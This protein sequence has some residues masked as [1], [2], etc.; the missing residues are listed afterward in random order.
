MR[1]LV[2]FASDLRS[3]IESIIST[4][5]I[6]INSLELVS[7]WLYPVRYLIP[8]THQGRSFKIGIPFLTIVLSVSNK[9]PITVSSS[10]YNRTSVSA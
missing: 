1:S 8:N 7:V 4:F 9:P 6:M 5:K 10:S 3:S 2:D